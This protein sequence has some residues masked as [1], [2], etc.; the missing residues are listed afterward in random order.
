M[1]ELKRYGI[2]LST[3][4]SVQRVLSETPFE[5]Q[6]GVYA[7]YSEA[8]AIIAHLTAERDQ[9]LAWGGDLQ[10][11][12]AARDKLLA[13]KDAEIERLRDYQTRTMFTEDENQRLRDAL[14]C[15]VECVEMNGFGKAYA[16]DISKQALAA[17]APTQPQPRATFTCPECSEASD[18]GD[19]D[20]HAG[21]V[22][23]CTSCGAQ[24]VIEP[25][26][27]DKPAQGGKVE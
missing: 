4:P 3:I 26:A 11:T 16:M 23:A 5:S 12:L 17:N 9:A 15:L 10:K 13:E 25:V 22:F 27:V 21:T 1:N 6:N 8:A 18:L 2:T 19:C 14:E 7:L 20:I 24:S